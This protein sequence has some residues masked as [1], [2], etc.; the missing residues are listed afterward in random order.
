MT[1]KI[2]DFFRN[3]LFSAPCG[4][5]LLDASFG[6]ISSMPHNRSTALII[7]DMLLCMSAVPLSIALE[8]AEARR[9]EILCLH[10]SV[11]G[12]VDLRAELVG[13]S[14]VIAPLMKHSARHGNLI[15]AAARA[16]VDAGEYNS[17]IVIDRGRVLGVSDQM[18]VSK[19][20]MRKGACMRCYRTSAGLMGLILSDDA[21]CPQLWHA[22]SRAECEFIVAMNEKVFDETREHAFL[23][24]MS[25]CCGREIYAH[26]CDVSH[27]YNCFGKC[28]ESACGIERPMSFSTHSKP[29]TFLRGTVKIYVEKA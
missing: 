6:T 26:F 2:G 1:S 7:C 19:K 14:D 9:P 16:V 28:E 13:E 29:D 21:H 12:R 25:Y 3:A 4:A 10:R 23:Q 22:M 20:G 18:S 15:V 11:I 27:R 5:K 8:Y 17:A 24:C